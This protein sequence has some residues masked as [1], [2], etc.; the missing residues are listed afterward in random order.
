ML[1]TPPSDNYL[2]DKVVE[3]ACGAEHTLARTSN[4]MVYGW[5][6]NRKNQLGLTSDYG[7][8]VHSP[9]RLQAK[10]A[11]GELLSNKRVISIAAGELYSLALTDRG[12]VYA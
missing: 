2:G 12:K 9:V 10:T 6:S 4:G 7:S 1:V 3:L 5:G 8:E 11:N